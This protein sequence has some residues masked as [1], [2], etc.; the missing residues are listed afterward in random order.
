MTARIHRTVR[1]RLAAA[2]DDEL[3]IAHAA[4]ADAR[5]LVAAVARRVAVREEGAS[6]LH[7]AEWRLHAALKRLDELDG[8][9]PPTDPGDDPDDPPA[10]A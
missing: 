7:T 6:A 1:S 10:A 4:V 5:E 9:E 3:G 8:R 2:P